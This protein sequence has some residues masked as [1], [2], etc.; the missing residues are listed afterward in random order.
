VPLLIR[1]LISHFG[2]G[3]VLGLVC[4]EVLLFSDAFQLGSLVEAS[5]NSGG[6]TLLF[7]AQ[8]ALL[9]GTVN[10]GVAVMNL[11]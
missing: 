1:F 11:R 9:F 6:M 7:F 8:A 10:M 2:N 5:R 4:A 3:V